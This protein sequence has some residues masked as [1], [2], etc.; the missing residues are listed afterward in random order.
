[1]IEFYKYLYVLST[2]IMK[3][4]FAKR[5]LKYNPL[6]NPKTKK[7]GTDTIAHK[8]AQLWIKLPTKYKNLPLLDLF[9]SK[10]KNW[11]CYDCPFNICRIFVDGVS[12]IS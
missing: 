2:P 1:M 6:P 5:D 11:H 7:Y 9:K 3:K 8:A 4:V 12:F 10:I